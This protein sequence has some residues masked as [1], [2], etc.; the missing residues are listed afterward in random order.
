MDE[1]NMLNRTIANETWLKKVET[2]TYWQLIKICS[3]WGKHWQAK[4]IIL[5][6]MQEITLAKAHGL[7]H[8]C[9]WRRYFLAVS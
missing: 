3:F 9:I 4:D 1:S 5:L 6:V 8:S 7:S 2:E